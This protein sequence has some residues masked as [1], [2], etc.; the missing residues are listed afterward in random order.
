MHDTTV[1][2]I[3]QVV[4][5]DTPYRIEDYDD[6]GVFSSGT[7]YDFYHED[8]GAEPEL[9]KKFGDSI[10][11]VAKVIDGTLVLVI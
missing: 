5:Y 7:V 3:L 2:D 1:H 8:N 11:S 4:L 6:G 10:V 9:P